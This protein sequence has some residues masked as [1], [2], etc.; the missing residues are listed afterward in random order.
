MGRVSVLIKLTRLNMDNHPPKGTADR[1]KR[2]DSQLPRE[3][4]LQTAV[5]EAKA[6]SGG[7]AET[8]L[9]E[10]AGKLYNPAKP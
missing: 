8:T 6:T 5:D 2:T 3:S 4:E 9:R 7:N 10:V 1:N